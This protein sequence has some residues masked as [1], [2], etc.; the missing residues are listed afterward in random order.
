MLECTC[1]IL[2]ANCSCEIVC[3][4]TIIPSVGPGLMESGLS[5]H[6]LLYV[7]KNAL[8]HSLYRYLAIRCAPVTIPPSATGCGSSPIGP[9]GARV[10]SIAPLHEIRPIPLPGCDIFQ[11]WEIQ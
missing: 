8:F 7:R 11:P 6:N 4:L 9:G 5:C 3:C 10:R 2:A 1:A